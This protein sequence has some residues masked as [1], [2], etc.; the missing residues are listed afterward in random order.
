IEPQDE[1]GEEQY[2]EVSPA[3]QKLVREAGDLYSFRE[4]QTHALMLAAMAADQDA[5]IAR[6]EALE[7]K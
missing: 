5:I 1:S 7:A 6:L 4:G 3:H 2:R